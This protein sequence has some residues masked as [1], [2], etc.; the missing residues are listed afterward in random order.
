MTLI[1]NKIVRILKWIIAVF[2]MMFGVPIIGH[3]TYVLM[4]PITVPTL[5]ISHLIM[6]FLSKITNEE[7]IPHIVGAF[8]AGLGVIPFVG[9]L[10]HWFTGIFILSE[11]LVD[12]KNKLMSAERYQEIK[13]EK[14]RA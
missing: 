7:Y 13:L 8:Q 10:G 14:E 11:G 9:W 3:F 1:S 2:H 12:K 6:I 4:L 5:L